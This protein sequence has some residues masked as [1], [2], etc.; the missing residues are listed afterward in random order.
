M[1]WEQCSCSHLL[2]TS[3]FEGININHP[4]PELL[5]FYCNW[6]HRAILAEEKGKKYRRKTQLYALPDINSSFSNMN[7]LG[8]YCWWTILSPTGFF[9]VVFFNTFSMLLLVASS[10]SG[11]T[12]QQ[13]EKIRVYMENSCSSSLELGWQNERTALWNENPFSLGMWWC[14]FF[15]KAALNQNCTNPFYSLFRL[16]PIIM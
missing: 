9:F 16:L 4:S 8:L 3:G 15:F 14:F 2:C 5:I 10:C 11:W 6:N 13:R 7:I 12:E 1:W